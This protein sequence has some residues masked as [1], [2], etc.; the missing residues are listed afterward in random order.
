[1]KKLF[2]SYL[3]IALLG[4]FLVTATSCGSVDPEPIDETEEIASAVLTLEPEGKGQLVT[5][6]YGEDSQTPTAVLNA[7]TTYIGNLTLYDPEG[8]DITGEISDEANDHEVF[9][10]PSSGLNLTV[11]KTDQDGN[12]RPLGLETSIMTNSASTGT[13]RVVLKH[14]PGSKGSTSNI[15]EGETDLSMT[16]NVVIQ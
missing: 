14:Q 13:M 6:T 5:I 10:E 2:K 11:Q 15:N 16:V 12:G 1:M 7:A 9:Y 8:N 4:S 3:S